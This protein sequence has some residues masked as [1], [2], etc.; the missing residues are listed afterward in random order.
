MTDLLLHQIFA[1]PIHGKHK[2]R[3]KN[4]KF[5]ISVTWNENFE[6]PDGLYSLSHI[7]N[8]FE[9]MGIKLV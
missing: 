9:Y 6:L 4:N 5:K 1:F 2:N 8:Y 7:Q 3:Y